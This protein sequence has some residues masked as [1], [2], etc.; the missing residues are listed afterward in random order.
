[1]TNAMCANLCSSASYTLAG[2]EAGSECYCG[3]SQGSLTAKQADSA[4]STTCAGTTGS[5]SGDWAI[6]VYSISG[7]ASTSSTVTSTTTSLTMSGAA[8]STT[9]SAPSPTASLLG[10]YQDQSARTLNGPTTSSSSMTPAVCQAWCLSQGSYTYWGVEYSQ[11]CY[12]SNNLSTNITLP[13]SSYTAKCAGDATQI[14][15]GTNWH[16]SI[17]QLSAGSTPTTSTAPTSTSSA[18]ATTATSWA[19]M[20]CHQDQSARTLAGSSITSSS[21]TPTFCQSFCTTGGFSYAGV[22]YGQECYCGNKLTVNTPLASTSCQIP[23]AGNSA[24]ICGGSNWQLS[25]YQLTTTTGSTSATP[26]TTSAASDPTSTTRTV[27]VQMFQWTFAS[28]AAECQYFLGSAGVGYVQVGPAQ[29]NWNGNGPW[30]DSYQPMSYSIGGKLG[31]RAAFASMVSACH[32]VGVGV[33]VDTVMN[34]QT[35]QASGTGVGGE[36]FTKYNYPGIYTTS[37]FHHSQCGTSD[38]QIHNY[39]NATEVQNC[40]LVG[41]ADLATETEHVR[42]TLAAY[43]NDLISLGVDGLRLDAAKHMPAADIANIL[44]R[45]SKGLYIT[46]EVIWGSGEPIQPSQ[47][48]GNGQVQEFRYTSTIQSAFGG[49]NIAQLQNINNYGWLASSSANAFVANHDTERGG[50]SLNYLSP[51]NQYTLAHVFGLSFAYGTQSILSSYSFSNYDQGA[52]N[53]GAGTCYGSGGV[54]GWLCQHRWTQIAG[55]IGF[56]NR[57]YGTSLSNWMSDASTHIAYGRGPVGFVAINIASSSW[58]TTFATSMPS[59]VY[60]DVVNGAMSSGV[61]TGPS[62]TVTDG[63]TFMATVSANNALAIHTGSKIA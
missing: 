6:S 40:E 30:W 42:G 47:Y 29:E 33:I 58:Q 52:P 16:I 5:C 53:S 7:A 50:T 3:S 59:G 48:V 56:S 14:F 35:A 25:L 38:G 11:E 61:C 28:I 4:C 18:P 2:T 23:C 54:N 20:G 51:N 21:M 8:T 13:A 12:C 37:D 24:L 34:H 39:Q 49:G 26:T 9:G 27:I 45:A 57:V 19:S 63:G 43:V 44:S 15:G 36:T 41:L 60:C 62:I 10:C 32:S 22:E 46:Q 17:Y 55:M 31:D 1:M